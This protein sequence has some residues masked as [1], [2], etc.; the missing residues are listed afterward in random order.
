[1]S[2]TKIIPHYLVLYKG[3]NATPTNETMSLIQGL[4]HKK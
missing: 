2:F 3:Q 4:I 1:M